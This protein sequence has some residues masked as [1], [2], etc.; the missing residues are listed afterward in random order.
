MIMASMAKKNNGLCVSPVLSK[1]NLEMV[2][3][4]KNNKTKYE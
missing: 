3:Y 2:R 1:K 4:K